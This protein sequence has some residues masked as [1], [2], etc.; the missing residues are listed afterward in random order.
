M[1]K[2]AEAFPRL[3]ICLCGDSL[4]ACEGFFER[5]REMG[6]R[7]ILRYKEGSIPYIAG[8]YR[9]LK[10][11]E[12]NYQERVLEDGKEWYDYVEDIDY[13][14]YHV[15]LVEY[16]SCRKRVYKKGKRKGEGVEDLV[17]RGRMRW[18][19]ENEGFNTQKKQG[20]HLEH[21]YSKDYQAMK[22]HYYLTQIGHMVAQAM[23]SWEK[24]WS[25]NRQ[26]REQRHQRVLESFKKVRLKEN[27]EEIGRR[28]QIRLE[29]E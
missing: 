13:N 14:G 17:Q 5:C 25:Q 2:I 15:N 22:N 11:K 4:Y 19:I 6:W 18:K 12:G 3:P 29:P 21:Q 9:A 23:E 7:Y 26:S 10:G 28:I 27:R 20:Y 24:L 8:E 1:E 16:G